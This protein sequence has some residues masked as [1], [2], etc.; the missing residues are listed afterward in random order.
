MPDKKEE[1]S[2]G[3]HRDAG[4][5][6]YVFRL[7]VTGASPHSARAVNNI[8][9]VCEAHLKDRYSLEIIDVYQQGDLAKNEQI[10]A[11]PLLVK[12][13]PLPERRLIGDLSDT[14]KVLKS[15]GLSV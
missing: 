12:K 8:K 11:L 4:G 2:A 10:V 5:P 13:H 6:D 3:Q 15:L 7:F 9:A 1:P 14:V